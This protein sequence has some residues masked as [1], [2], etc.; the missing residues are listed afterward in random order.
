MD[1][2]DSQKEG[3]N[4]PTRHQSYVSKDSKPSSIIHVSAHNEGLNIEEVPHED[5]QHS[6]FDFLERNQAS[7]AKWKRKV[8]VVIDGPWF[9][10]ASII[11][12]LMVRRL[13]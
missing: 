10:L 3:S 9:T 5:N 6:I 4:I 12:T 1:N 7:K 13:L 2:G 11:F 8:E